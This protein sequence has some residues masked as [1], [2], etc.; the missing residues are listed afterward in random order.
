MLPLTLTAQLQ[1]HDESITTLTAHQDYTMSVTG[2]ANKVLP[3]LFQSAVKTYNS[4][5]SPLAFNANSTIISNNWPHV[6]ASISNHTIYSYPDAQH[7]I[8]NGGA[9]LAQSGTIVDGHIKIFIAHQVCFQ[10]CDDRDWS[11][12]KPCLQVSHYCC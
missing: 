9:P 7:T 8:P 3:I 1:S 2:T 5:R 4:F 11:L 6:Q 10:I 12:Q